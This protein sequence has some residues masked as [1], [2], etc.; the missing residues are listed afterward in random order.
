MPYT[1]RFYLYL[2]AAGV[3]VLV[4]AVRLAPLGLLV[5]LIF[6]FGAA[7]LTIIVGRRLFGRNNLSHS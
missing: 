1:L 2:F 5:N 3:L 6:G 4:V 7:Y